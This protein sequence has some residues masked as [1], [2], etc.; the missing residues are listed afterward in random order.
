[1]A[2]Q[3]LGLPGFVSGSALWNF[4]SYILEFTWPLVQITK[5]GPL[6]MAALALANSPARR[7]HFLLHIPI[8]TSNTL[9]PIKKH[10][11]R[12]LP[13]LVYKGR[14][15][16]AFC[17]VLRFILQLLELK[18]SRPHLPTPGQAG[19]TPPKK[20]GFYFRHRKKRPYVSISDVG[21]A[22]ESP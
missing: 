3:S 16:F 6:K 22:L 10:R 4:L 1:M 14:T 9:A 15:R 17:F 2:A 11:P 21:Y 13:A 8:S 20:S 19:C 18:D 7:C 5:R 12:Q